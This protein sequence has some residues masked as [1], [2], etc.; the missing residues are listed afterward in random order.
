MEK[1]ELICIGCPLGCPLTVTAEGSAED[2]K[3]G[4][5]SEDKITVAG[6]TCP[7]GERY[8]KNEVLHPERMITSTVPVEGGELV[9][10]PVKTATAVPKGRIFA[11]M[12][13]IHKVTANAPVAIG[14]VVLK[15]CAGTG[16]D[17][18]ATGNVAKAGDAG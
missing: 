1:R 18:I 17:I 9:R 2:L 7:N 11:C 13:E 6:N 12:E 5:V 4:K 8:A 16:V 14:D 10:V 3:A 15:N